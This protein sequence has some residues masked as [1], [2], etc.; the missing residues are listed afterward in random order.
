MSTEG[1]I[2]TSG[3]KKHKKRKNS[4]LEREEDNLHF[5]DESR[6]KKKTKTK[7]LGDISEGVSDVDFGVD[8]AKSSR[9]EKKRKDVSGVDVEKLEGDNQSKG[10]MKKGKTGDR[11]RASKVLEASGERVNEESLDWEVSKLD[12]R[13]R[14]KIHVEKNDGKNMDQKE[15]NSAE[16]FDAGVASDIE[17]LKGGEVHSREGHAKKKTK[18]KNKTELKG[19]KKPKD[20]V[21]DASFVESQAHN[22]VIE[23]AQPVKNKK[24]KNVKEDLGDGSFSKDFLGNSDANA[25]SNGEDSQLGGISNNEQVKMKKKKKNKAEKCKDAD[26]AGAS[27]TLNIKGSVSHSD[28]FDNQIGNEENQNVQSMM[29]KKGKRKKKD[30]SGAVILGKE[31]E[32]STHAASISSTQKSRDRGSKKRKEKLYG[33]NTEGDANAGANGSNE[34]NE[35]AEPSENSNRNKKPKKVKFSENVEVFPLPDVSSKGKEKV[36]DGSKEKKNVNDGLIQGKR[37]SKEEDEIIQNAVYK[38][39]EDHQLGEE[40][41]QM[42]LNCMSHPEVKGCWKE[43]GEALPRRPYTAVYYRAHIL[44]ERSEERKWTP[45]EIELVKQFHAKHGPDWKTLSTELGKHRFHVKDLWRRIK[46]PNMKKGNWSQEEYQNLFNLVNVDLSMKAFA[47][48][49]TKH[50]M[51]RDNICWEAISDQL[52]TR[53]NSLCCMKWYRSLTSPMVA[54]GKWANADDYRLL[55]AL[56]DLDAACEDDVDWDNLLDHRSGD[57]CRKRWNQMVRHIGEHG[58][59]PFNEQ[60]DILSQRYCPDLLE[61]RESYDNRPPVD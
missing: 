42:V 51:L 12:R 14:E 36:E 61:A 10:K 1:D 8:I 33:F 52:T 15:K 47:E 29:D 50:G 5:A 54:E 26:Y 18:T 30:D 55:I 7:V 48:K 23:K 13:K 39:I 57:V 41:L 19:K 9:K 4:D 3:K 16:K 38:Y 60:V 21:D 28:L 2:F 25:A 46:L 17:L 27:E 59:K 56:Y 32:K 37:F 58:T 44:F 43:I 6:P 35:T 20:N 53:S 11:G 24:Q 40:G 31:P 49:K 22:E 34:G 45:E